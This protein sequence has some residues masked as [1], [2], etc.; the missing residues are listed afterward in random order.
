M[1]VGGP[2]LTIALL[3]H[4]LFG[5]L[6]P[7]PIA[8]PHRSN[9]PAGCSPVDRC[10]VLGQVSDATDCQSHGSPPATTT[11]IP[12]LPLVYSLSTGPD[13]GEDRAGT[14]MF[15]SFGTSAAENSLGNLL[16]L[17]A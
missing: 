2:N 10:P 3:R 12:Y 11:W 9:E 1:K 14:D 6:E 8:L 13:N 4:Q 16:D 17:F 15:L 5:P 7:H